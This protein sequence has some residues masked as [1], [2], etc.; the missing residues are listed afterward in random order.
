MVDFTKSFHSGLTLCALIHP[1]RPKLVD[2]DKLNPA[3]SIGNIKVAFEAAEKYFGLDQYLKPEDISKLDEKSMIVYVSEYY[4]GI[5][6]QRKMDIA[7][8]RIA[9]LIKNTQ[10]NDAMRAEYLDKGKQLKALLDKV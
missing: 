3:D 10:L 4:S 9:K 8:R 1:F 7:G 5:A 2:F 6:A